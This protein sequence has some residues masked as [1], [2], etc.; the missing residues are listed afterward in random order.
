MASEDT[1]IGTCTDVYPR[2]EKA[3]HNEHAHSFL[4]ADLIF[5]ICSLLS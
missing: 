3:A 4:T 5:F 1:L 2:F